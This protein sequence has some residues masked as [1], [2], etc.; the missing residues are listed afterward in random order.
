MTYGS[1]I[2]T[3]I[4]LT[5]PALTNDSDFNNSEFLINLYKVFGRYA[6]ISIDA[7]IDPVNFAV[8]ERVY[9][10]AA[11]GALYVGTVATKINNPHTGGGNPLFHENRCI[12]KAV[13][14]LNLE[15]L[16]NDFSVISGIN[17]IN[18]RPFEI[19]IKSD[20]TNTTAFTRPSTMYVFC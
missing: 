1:A 15:T 5:K 16:N 18:N 14:G 4:T 11:T 12:G 19:N 3:G 8:N 13:F 17:T 20:G 7:F 10:P 6:D 2:G 9:D